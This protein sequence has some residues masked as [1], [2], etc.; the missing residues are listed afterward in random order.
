MFRLWVLVAVTAAATACVARS[1]YD[2]LASSNDSLTEE[3]DEL[4]SEVQGLELERDS[5]QSEFYEALESYEDE[6]ERRSALEGNLA[7]IE[8]KADEL[9]REL[10]TERGARADIAAALAAREAEIAAIQASYDRIVTDLES[11]VSSGQIE[12]ERLREGL[13]LN[14][15]DDVLFASGSAD[16]DATGVEVLKRVAEQLLAVGDFVE[17]SGHTDDRRIRGILARTYPTNWELAAARAARVVRLLEAEGVSGTR[18]AVVSR[19]P[20]DPVVANDTPENRARNRRIE[21]RLIPRPPQ[22]GIPDA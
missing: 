22:R 18:L 9:D 2:A 8:A 6:R 3:R 20:N 16:L 21:I 10:V 14:V 12:I 17:V 5:L 15:S 11:E 7:D 13:R 1:S 19:G 4:V